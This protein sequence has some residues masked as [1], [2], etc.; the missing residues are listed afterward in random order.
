MKK[1]R[2]SATQNEEFLLKNGSKIKNLRKKSCSEAFTRF[3]DFDIK[4]PGDSHSREVN[5]SVFDRKT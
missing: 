5:N 3:F 4:I 1:Y 2:V